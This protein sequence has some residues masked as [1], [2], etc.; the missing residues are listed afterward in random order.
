MSERLD[1][2]KLVK[3]RRW[4]RQDP[5]DNIGVSTYALIKDAIKEG[6]KELAK[7]LTDYLY[8]WEIKFVL[9]ANIDLVGG[10]PQ[11]F[12]THYGEDRLYDTYREMLLRCRGLASWPVPP[13]KKR[14][15]TPFEWSMDYA[16][17]MVRL[18]RMGKN[19]GT[20]GFNLEEYDDRYEVVWDPCYTG[21]RTRRGDP[22]AY[23]APHIAPPFNY[24]VNK[25][26]HTWTGGKTGMTGY[27]IHCYLLHE[28]LDIEQTGY[29]GQWIVGYPE[30]PWKPCPYIVYKDAD[31]IPEECYNR[32]GKT[33]PK[34]KSTA[35][36]PKDP[37]LLKVTHSDELGRRWTNTVPLLKKAIDAG[38]KEEALKLIDELD[39][40]RRIH[41]YPLTWNW[42]WLDIIAERYGYN[43]LYHALRSL[44]SRMEPPL[45][46]DEPKPAKDSIPSAEERAR[47][48]ALWGRGDRSGPDESSVRIIDEPDRIV[49]ELNPCGSVGQGLM[50]ID[51]VD[52]VTAAV[53]KELKVTGLER[54][55]L[56]E[57]PF[58]FKV[59]TEPH[60]VAWGKVG[61]PHLCT[62]CC[63]HFEM[64]AIARNGYL[65]TVVERPAN[66]TDPNCRWFFYKNLDNIPE[67][68][69]TRIGAIKPAR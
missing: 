52:Y 14:D 33:K 17:R 19:D 31:W 15:I 43:E 53:A 12:M 69:Y 23:T 63:V 61:V 62:R 49:M 68:Y 20:G 58:N 30:D 22:I 36:K 45:A 56:T 4:E 1:K 67:E 25:V 42:V 65:T 28:L 9:D 16:A 2:V 54:G 51:K 35:P 50:R 32:I 18:H 26:P 59:T 27:C 55:P 57:P 48:A 39:A 64:A 38:N 5:M 11:F 60:P 41:R 21:G 34:V 47:K 29:L 7:D 40:E 44:Y 37:K 10:F 3:R 24:T 6:K 8:F 66:A 46:P 13:V